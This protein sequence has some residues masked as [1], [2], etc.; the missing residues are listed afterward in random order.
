M[1]TFVPLFYTSTDGKGFTTTWTGAYLGTEQSD[2]ILPEY[3]PY[4]PYMDFP[5]YRFMGLGGDD[6]IVGGTYYEDA[7]LAN[8]ATLELRGERD[9]IHGGSG[10]DE[11]YG[12]AFVLFHAE[13]AGPQE[14]PTVE[15]FGGNDIILGQEG[16]D[17]I[18]GDAKAEAG[19]SA[20]LTV[21]G[22]DDYLSG[23]ADNDTIY[24][25]GSTYVVGW[26]SSNIVGGDDEIRGDDGD[27]Y[28]IGDGVAS[29][30]S[31]FVGTTNLIGGNDTIFGGRGNDR[32]LGDDNANSESGNTRKYGADLIFAGE[33]NDYVSG[34]G[35]I[36]F[37]AQDVT[38]GV[39][40]IL[41]GA[42]EDTLLGD[43]QVNTGAAL[44]P[45]DLAGDRIEGGEGADLII[46]DSGT[47][48]GGSIRYSGAIYQF[49]NGG[50]DVLIGDAGNDTVIGDFHVAVVD[51]N[52][53]PDN[54]KNGG[55]DWLGGGTG[56][57]VL[58]GDAYLY[59]VYS[60][61]WGL[62]HTIGDGAFAGG[63]D[64]LYGGAGDD[65]MFGDFA[66]GADFSDP[67]AVAGTV[68]GGQDQFIFDASGGADVIM[69]FRSAE[70]DE[71]LLMQLQ[72][73]WDDLDTNGNGTLDAADAYITT[74]DGSTVIDIGAASSAIGTGTIATI[75]VADVTDLTAEDFY[76]GITPV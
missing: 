15:I 4:S 71:I 53:A 56:N 52:P 40:T 28:L 44:T 26:G 2:F 42:G 62:D 33:G 3:R 46:G 70:G 18:F 64:S 41:G 76:F 34:D 31:F 43:G 36:S 29:V 65:T 45:L 58:I 27:D 72:L 69:D 12:D 50:D 48:L 55:D 30:V 47:P 11:L 51:P 61:P 49:L 73:A 25:D 60:L 75:T 63:N 20:N 67:D 68:G 13:E 57:D 54:L 66:Y 6:T 8:D 1:A 32:I 22:G 9:E 14:K 5:F 24:G 7:I 38:F 17:V 21:N 74:V 37:G 10:N 16:A 59:S 23:G 39:D 19:S 35:A